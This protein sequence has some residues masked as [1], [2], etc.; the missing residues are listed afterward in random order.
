MRQLEEARR[1][2][3]KIP[4]IFLNEDYQYSLRAFT[5]QDGRTMPLP[6][7]MA[8]DLV[9]GLQLDLL[10]IH[11]TGLDTAITSQKT[12]KGKGLRALLSTPGL[13]NANAPVPTVATPKPDPPARA[14]PVR[15]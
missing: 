9:A 11:H 12:A 8:Q 10:Q 7:L 15:A 14:L 5:Y 6:R 3:R 13:E 4:G 2:I 1:A